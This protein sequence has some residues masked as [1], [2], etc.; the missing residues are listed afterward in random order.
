VIARNSY[1]PES[2]PAVAAG[3]AHGIRR[4][5]RAGLPDAVFAPL[6]EMSSEPA[7]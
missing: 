3:E 1:R 4:R 2:V 7:A 5:E 6:P